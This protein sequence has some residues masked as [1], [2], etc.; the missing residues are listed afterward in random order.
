MRPNPR[1]ALVYPSSQESVRTLYTF[2]K[3]QNIG[4]KPPQSIL[5]LATY[6]RGKGFTDVHCLD[7]QVEGLSP[8]QTVDA[9]AALEPDIIGITAWTDFWY[10]VHKTLQIVR[11][12]LPDATLV[13]GGPHAAIYP[14]ETLLGSEADYVVAG[15]GEDVLLELVR[16]L[17][18]SES[19]PELP[20]LWRR[21]GGGSVAPQIPIAMVN[22]LSAIPVPDR[23]LLP[24]KKYS[25]IL[26]PADYE[27]TMITS[28]GC[29][30]KCVF[31]KMDV[32]KVYARTAA[33]VVE[34]FRQIEAL[35]IRD[36]Q[37]YDDTFTWGHK[38][39]LDICDGIID[40]GIKVNWAI[41]DRVNR[42]T[43]ELYAKLKQAGCSRVHFGVET[44][45][46]QILKNSGKFMNLEQVHE[47]V[48]IAKSVKMTVMTYFMFGFLQETPE[49]ARM[50]ID[51]AKTL[52]PDYVS[53]GVLVPYPGTEIYRK[54][55]AQGI[56]PRDYWHDFALD[57]QPDY[58]IPH[59]IEDV[60]DRN[61]LISL[62]DSATRDFYFRPLRLLKELAGLRSFREFSA[63]A[64]LGAS[65]LFDGLK[66]PSSSVYR[67]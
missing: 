5:I 22:D 2:N 66:T 17:R 55:L 51:L 60:M 29:P 53:F 4:F 56:I 61:E 36:V 1:I 59:L 46:P 6:L 43:P 3:N 23:T 62:K 52:N 39:A 7:A 67:Y 12:R 31:C 27:T 8:A 37:V 65:I 10:P 33:Q 50:T 63:K 34:E 40:A 19:V 57:P 48:R 64:R 45:S 21:D 15:D 9:L 58:Q 30:Y 20:G 28:R 54:G 18:A 26:T 14:E 11:K 42:V 44:G 16:S 35:G 25:S 47:G 32:Q 38:R 41:R 13:V 24:Y 49:D